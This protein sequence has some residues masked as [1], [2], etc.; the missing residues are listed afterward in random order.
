MTIFIKET[1]MYNKNEEPQNVIIVVGPVTLPLLI[2][3]LSSDSGVGKHAV[4]KYIIILRNKIFKRERRELFLGD[5]CA[6]FLPQK[7]YIQRIT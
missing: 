1:K 2:D 5:Q 6:T 3:A 4:V 7:K